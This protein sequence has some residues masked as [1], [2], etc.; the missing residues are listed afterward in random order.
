MYPFPQMHQDF[1]TG[2]KKREMLAHAKHIIK[3]HP[4]HHIHRLILKIIA[5]V[6]FLAVALFELAGA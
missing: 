1:Y 5:G 6:V 2:V 4:H 3:S